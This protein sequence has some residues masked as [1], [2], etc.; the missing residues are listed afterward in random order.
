MHAL[1]CSAP[2]QTLDV[3]TKRQPGWSVSDRH[4]ATG[5]LPLRRPTCSLPAPPRARPAPAAVTRFLARA[6]RGA[7]TVV[8]SSIKWSTAASGRVVISFPAADF[9]SKAAGAYS[10]AAA[11]VNANGEGPYCSPAVAW[12]LG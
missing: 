1:Q 8:P 12:T 6:V 3:F 5:T 9:A 4:Q 7:T 2:R 10:F 11:A